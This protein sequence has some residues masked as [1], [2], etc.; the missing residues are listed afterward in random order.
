MDDLLCIICSN[1]VS[2]IH[3]VTAGER[4]YPNPSVSC[5]FSSTVDDQGRGTDWTGL[6]GVWQASSQPH[7]SGDPLGHQASPVKAEGAVEIRNIFFSKIVHCL[8][9]ELCV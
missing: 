1:T 7:A 8:L 2:L 9:F 3:S 5:L 6:L 4:A